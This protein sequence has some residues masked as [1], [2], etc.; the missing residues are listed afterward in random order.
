M[1]KCKNDSKASYIGTEPSPKGL[2]FCAHAEKNGTI[3]KGKDG[4]EWIIKTHNNI[5]KWQKVKIVLI[6]KNISKLTNMQLLNNFNLLLK[7]NKINDKTLMR[8]FGETTDKIRERKLLIVNSIVDTKILSTKKIGK[9]SMHVND[10]IIISDPSYVV[11]SSLNAKIKVMSGDYYC[12][13]NMWYDSVPNNL[14]IV[15]KNHIDTDNEEIKFTFKKHGLAVDVANLVVMNLSDYPKL[16]TN[17]QLDWFENNNIAYDSAKMYKKLNN[18]YSIRTGYGD[19]RY[20]YSI[21]KVNNNV[22]NTIV[23]LCLI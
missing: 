2:G 5:K 21:G 18:G 7:E 16:S 9:V 8:V 1:P 22:L 3:K 11:N 17:D 20:D 13:F 6:K 10:K 12:Y 4:N 14:V 19:G 23:I 15:H